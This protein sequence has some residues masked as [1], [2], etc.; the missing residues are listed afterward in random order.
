MK[1]SE[2]ARRGSGQG[3]TDPGLLAR[4]LDFISEDHLRERQICTEID[5]LVAAETFDRPAGVTILRF[6]NEE[7]GVHLRD[8]VEDLFPTLA[9]RCTDEDSIASVLGRI[10][11]DQDQALSLLPSVRGAIANCLDAGAD[12]SSED[13]EVLACFAAHV[14][15]HLV[16]ENAILLPIARARLTRG[17]LR[18]LANHMRLRRGL[19]TSQGVTS[20]E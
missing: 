2:P 15:R 20:A 3:P 9:R 17:D 18:R 1:Q 14:R 11:H 5:R 16:A 10:R 7:L 19:P 4:P 13:R 12:L 8:E 6:L